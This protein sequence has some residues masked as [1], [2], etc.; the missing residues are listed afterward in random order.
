[1]KRTSR[2]VSYVVLIL[3]S[4][5]LIPT[6]GIAPSHASGGANNE[7]VNG[8]FE[9][10][11]LV[12]NGGFEET[13]AGKPIDWVKFHADSV[14]ESVTTPV[15]GGSHSVKLT[16]NGANGIRSNHIKVYPGESYTASVYS[17]NESGTS[18]W[19]LEFWDKNNRRIGVKTARNNVIGSWEKMVIS[20][21][22]PENTAYATVLLYQNSRNKGIA[23]YDDASLDIDPSV[24]P[25]QSLKVTDIS[26]G[27]SSKT[28]GDALLVEST[29]PGQYIEFE[30]PVQTSGI[31]DIRVE[32]LTS[33]NGGKANVLWDGAPI[34]VIDFYKGGDVGADIR[35]LFATKRFE[36]GNH[37]LTFQVTGKDSDSGGFNMLPSQVAF[38]LDLLKEALQG[39]NDEIRG[40]RELLGT[41]AAKVPSGN[42]A[43]DQWLRGQASQLS[44]QLDELQAQG[45][46]GDS[47]YQTAL[48]LVT[49]AKQMKWGIVRFGNFVDARS[50]NPRSPFGLLTADSMTLV[51]PRDLPCQCS[52]GPASLSLAKGEYENIQAV[53]LPYGE[54]LKGVDARVKSI[55]GPNGED[56]STS[57]L[58]VS[59]NPLGSVKL[60]PKLYSIPATA[61]SPGDYYG[62]TPDPIRSDLDSVDVPAGRMQP[63]WIDVHAGPQAKPGVY[64]VSVTFSANGL[65]PETQRID[66]DVWP[67]SIPDRPELTTSLSTNPLNI[68]STYSLTDPDEQAKMYDTYL[69]FMETFKI[70]PDNIYRNTPPTV[71]ELLKIKQR[72]GLHHFNVLYIDPRVGFDLSHPE[73]WQK[74]VDY[75]LQTIGDAMQQYRQAGLVKYAYVYGFDESRPKYRELEKYILQ[76]LKERFPDL[77]VMSTTLDRSLGEQSGLKNIDIWVPGVQ[78]FDQA[79]AVRAQQR[80]DKVYW[81]LHQGV[82]APYPDWFN[83]YPPID[84]RVLIGPMTHKF[85]LD[86]F[87]YYNITRWVD[88]SPMSDGILSSWDPRTFPTADGDGSLFYPGPEGPLASQ[89]LENFRDGMEDY[90]LLNELQESIEQARDVP[91]KL[92]TR[93]KELLSGDGVVSTNKEYTKAAGVYRQWREDVAQM[94]FI[95]EPSANVGDV[96]QLIDWYV[97]S[98][99]LQE[100]LAVQLS[101]NLKQAQHQLEAGS[102][103]EAVRDMQE[104]MKHLHN[105]AMGRFVSEDAKQ[106]LDFKANSLIQAWAGE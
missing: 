31:Y 35:R 67:I 9:S 106:G 87:L 98:G 12:A 92:L 74:R 18:D 75:L 30:V 95:L 17:Y 36:A 72:W 20:M 66:V 23:Y 25:I 62:W 27:V 93:A 46:Q 55:I 34:G 101:N 19:Y 7:P 73:T 91:P 15:H 37:S 22:A 50:A 102:K 24:Y 47:D 81:Y 83:G 3:L 84:T 54:T 88:R 105:E 69:D 82:R 71:D 57:A 41:V 99:D 32:G 59:V 65:K 49:E 100:P 53:V 11:N 80:G 10:V 4:F 48:E 13:S 1:M 28:V 103:R 29:K 16:S 56:V 76:Q 96:Q 8:D 61:N 21:S 90:N 14:Y 33:P 45:Q 44:A 40:D 26:E 64:R 52:T 94:I 60:T 58:S 70:E 89:R 77:P 79:A 104:F 63:Y 78:A 39:L 2:V 43:P 6:V 68:Y 85:N 38:K 86:G 97:A 51:Y 42:K 5:G